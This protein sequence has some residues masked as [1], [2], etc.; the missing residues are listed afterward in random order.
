MQT[1]WITY[2]G[3]RHPVIAKNIEQA[4]TILLIRL[5]R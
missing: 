4:Q 2:Q 1:F 5:G 3:E